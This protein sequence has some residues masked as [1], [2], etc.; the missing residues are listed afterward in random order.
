MKIRGT[1]LLAAISMA[2]LPS[3]TL[4]A[5]WNA[6]KDFSLS[7][8]P[9]SIWQYGYGTAGS[10]FTQLTYADLRVGGGHTTES[11][12]TPF[13]NPWD[14]PLID[15][16]VSGSAFVRG[17]GIV[18]PD[19]L[20]VHPGE[21]SDVIIQWTAPSAGIYSFSGLFQLQDAYPTGVIGEVYANAT[22]LFAGTLTG[23]GADL[24][25]ATPG[26]SELFSGSRALS[27][28]DKLYFAVNDDGDYGF[29][30][31]GF[32]VTISNGVPELPQW[33][34]L[35]V[36]FGLTGATMRRRRKIDYKPV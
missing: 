36:G 19:A 6:L 26:Q 18:T 31:T 1:I 16:E 21:T 8:S 30:Y 23:P 15:R 33:A 11:W 14:I 32:N 5:T 35:I 28:G 12:D 4:G 22:P 25:T 27:A 13:Q 34:M 24:A 7:Q 17:T 2:A 3:P 29:D 9:T 10:T 20:G